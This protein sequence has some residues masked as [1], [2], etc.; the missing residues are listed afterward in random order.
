MNKIREYTLVAIFGAAGYFLLEIFWRGYSHW[1]MAL[2]GG[3]GLAGIYFM[4]AMLRSCG[5]FQKCAVG[6]I[7]LTGLE[8]AAGV[9]VNLVLGWHVWDYSRQPGNL[10]GQICPLYSLYWFLLCLALIPL[11]GWIRR[12]LSVRP[13]REG[14]G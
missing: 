13:S 1:T 3:V 10:L 5:L 14:A 2:A 11:C 4:D 8:L 7:L 12:E 9:V 6:C